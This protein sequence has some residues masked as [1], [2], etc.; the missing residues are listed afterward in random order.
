VNPKKKKN[1]RREN[2]PE[3]L[4]GSKRVKG[5]MTR[6]SGKSPSRWLW[7]GARGGGF[8]TFSGGK[9]TCE[10]KKRRRS[11]T[12]QQLL[13][14]PGKGL[15]VNQKDGQ[16]PKTQKK[17]KKK[18]N[19]NSL[20]DCGGRRKEERDKRKENL[21]G[22]LPDRKSP[23]HKRKIRNGGAHKIKKSRKKK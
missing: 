3:T 1:G 20:P 21:K 4:R 5:G 23:R 12:N 11:S 14:R 8:E 19:S 22:D 2:K 10:K 15:E 6:K 9:G 13:E 18:K 7:V 17:K 16:K